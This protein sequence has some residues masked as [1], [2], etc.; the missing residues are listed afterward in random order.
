MQRIVRP[1]LMMAL[2]SGAMLSAFAAEPAPAPLMPPAAPEVSVVTVLGKLPKRPSA[3]VRRLNRSSASSCG[4]SSLGHADDLIDAYLDH[5]EG[6][7][8]NTSNV[9]NNAP[10]DA[11]TGTGDNPTPDALPEGFSDTSPSGDDSTGSANRPGLR[12]P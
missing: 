7:G 9:T 1:P 10:S 4:F 6:R 12:P 5:F 8:R 3:N 11:L 2:L